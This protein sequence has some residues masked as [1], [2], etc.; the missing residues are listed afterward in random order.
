METKDIHLVYGTDDNY[1]FPTAVSAASAA[2]YLRPGERLTLHLFDLG[3]SDAHYEEY[4]ALVRRANATDAVSLVRHRLNK[5]MFEGFGAWRGSVVTYSRMMMEELLPDLDW[6]IY[7]DGDTLWLG[8]PGELWDLR[9][10]SKLILASVDPPTPMGTENPEFAWYRERGL[11]VDASGYLCMGLMLANLKAMREARIA[12]RCRA[13][14][15][16]F[17]NPR[18]V[19]QTVLNLVCQGRTAP[20]PPQWGVFSVWHG[21]VDLSKPSA[22]HYVTDV[23]WK[24]Q[25]LNRLFSDVVLLWFEFCKRVLGRDELARF[26]PWCRFWR[27]GAFVILKHCQWALNVHPYVKSR[28][29]NTHGIPRHAYQSIVERWTRGGQA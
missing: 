25:K 7:F 21:S 29:R 22:V 23:P 8:S 5:E 17:P 2:F 13:F 1:V 26:S 9:D 20:L 27:R 18:V 12:A 19:D 14:M 28:L 11:D 10:E 6:A 4:C 16:E 24:R 15:K 3:V